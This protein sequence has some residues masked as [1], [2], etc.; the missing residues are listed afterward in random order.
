MLIDV[1]PTRGRSSHEDIR[2]RSAGSF[3]LSSSSSNG[4]GTLALKSRRWFSGI[5][6]HR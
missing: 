1:S 6:E 4:I 3:H 2:A 5:R